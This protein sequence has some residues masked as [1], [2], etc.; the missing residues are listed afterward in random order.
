MDTKKKVLVIG[1]EFSSGSYET[2]QPERL[3][4]MPRDEHVSSIGWYD[5][6]DCLDGRAIDVYSMPDLGWLAYSHF[7][8]NLRDSDSLAQYDLL[9]VQE[10]YEPRFGILGNQFTSEFAESPASDRKL[11][12][13]HRCYR[14][15]PST[16]VMTCDESGIS[17]YKNFVSRNIDAHR[18]PRLVAEEVLSDISD[19][20]YVQTLLHASQL[21]VRNMAA[22]LGLRMLVVSFSTPHIPCVD[23]IEH[24]P[25]N[26]LSDVYPAVCLP[27]RDDYLTLPTKGIGARGGRL[28]LQG[29]QL[30]GNKINELIKASLP[31]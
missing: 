29:N 22:E 7:L 27:N 31:S 23:Q 4:D 16:M 2:R 30:L 28:T 17:F 21:L 9:I 18:V 6:L 13:R 19:S 26:L 10:T 8:R 1:C 11:N 3:G 20:S 14:G 24:G 12:L 25:V 15:S 5:Y